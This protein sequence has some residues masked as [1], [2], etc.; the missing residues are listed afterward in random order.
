MNRQELLRRIQMLGFA[1][2]EAN[3]YLNTHP[4]D[5]AALG[6]Y[7]KY[8]VLYKQSVEEYEDTYG[9]LTSYGVNTEDGWSWINSPWPWELEG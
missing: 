7:D 8:N 5:K 1:V 2:A 9:P 4:H 6:Y 3:L